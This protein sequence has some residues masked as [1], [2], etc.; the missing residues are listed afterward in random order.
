MKNFEFSVADMDCK[1]CV[2]VVMRKLKSF[3]GIK[4]VR[5]DLA[6]KKVTVEAENPDICQDD[7]TCA[8]E[9]LGYKV[10]LP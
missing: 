4:D 8:V 1:S 3:E 2:N 5:I 9:S 10:H 6:R 7:L